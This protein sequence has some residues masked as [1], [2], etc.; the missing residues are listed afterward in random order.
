AL[1]GMQ[2][3]GAG[4]FAI[5]DAVQALKWVKAN[6]AAFGGDPGRVTIAGQSAGS[7]NVRTVMSTPLSKGLYQRAIMHS[8]P[9]VMAQPGKPNF[10]TLEAKAAAAAPVF[11]KLFAGKTVDDLRKLPVEELYRNEARLN[12]MF[13]VTSNMYAVIDG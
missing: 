10:V 3:E 7:R 11:E 5:L 13:A 8:S 12:E 9:T 4:N 2:E 6:I 1:P